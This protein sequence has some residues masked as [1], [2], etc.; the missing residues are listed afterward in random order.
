MG[1]SFYLVDRRPLCH[2][3]ERISCYSRVSKKRA[4]KNLQYSVIKHRTGRFFNRHCIYTRYHYNDT[5]RSP[6]LSWILTHDKQSGRKLRGFLYF[7]FSVPPDCCCLGKFRGRTEMD[8]LQ[9]NYG[10]TTYHQVRNIR[11]VLDDFYMAASIRYDVCY[12][13]QLGETNLDYDCEFLWNR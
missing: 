4:A 12:R 9:R 6:R 8:A 2:T 7:L 13:G 11:L 3:N 10:K 1:G 5:N